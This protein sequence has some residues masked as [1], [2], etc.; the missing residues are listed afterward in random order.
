MKL[1]RT[2]SAI[3]AMVC[4]WLLTGL[5]CLWG[6]V[7][8][9]AA[10]VGVVTDSSGAVVP[11]AEV[12]AAHLETGLRRT[13]V[14]DG[15]GNFAILSLPIGPYAISVSAK[16]FKT[17]RLERTVLTVGE[18]QRLAPVLEVGQVTESIVVESTAELMQ[19]EKSSVGAVVQEK[20][21][22]DLPLNGRNPVQLVMLVPGMRF[23]LSRGGQELGSYVQGLGH[24]SDQTEFQLDGVTANSG[25]DEQ[26]MAIPNVDTIAEF[27]VETASFSAEYG[28]MPLQVLMATKAGTNELHG[29]LWEFLRNEKLD[30]F[31]A[32]AKTPGARKP[33]LSRNQFGAAVG[34]PIVRDRTHF[35]GS[36]EGTTIRQESIYNSTVVQPAML[37]GDFSALAKAIRDPLAGSPFPGNRI[38]ESRFSAASKYF[39]PYILLPNSPDGR[40]RAN[41]PNPNTNHEVTA[42]IDHQFT[43][44]HRLFGRWIIVKNAADPP[45]YK[46]D[47]IQER[48]VRQDSVALNYNWTIT[49][50]TLFTLSAGYMRHGLDF[51][52]AVAG[53]ENLAEKAGIQGIVT[54]GREAFVGLPTVAF[55][56][57]TGFSAPWGVPGRL[58]FNAENGKAGFNL[59]RGGHTLNFGYE[60][61]LRNTLG[62]HGSHSV[63]GNFTFNSQY[64]GDGFAD[65]LL[66]L[67]A[68][69]M[70]NYPIDTFGMSD[71]PYSGLY[72]QDFWRVHRNVTLNLGVRFDY[73]HE[74]AFV[75]GN[76]A[77]FDPRIGKGLA[78]E[79]KTGKV[80]LDAQPTARYLAEA[81]KGLWIPASQAGVPAGLFRATGFVSPRLGIAWR[82]LGRNDFVIRTGYGL[83]PSGLRGN[84]TASTIVGPP[85]WSIEQRIF[86]PATLQRWET[87]WPVDP[88]AWTTPS[89]S[90]A[91]DWKLDPTKAHEFNVSVQTALPMKSALTV[92]YVGV[93]VFDAIQRIA[94]NEVPPGRYVDLQAAKPYPVIGPIY[95]FQNTITK[96]GETWYNG[97]QVKWER[98]FV[99]GLSYTLSYAFSKQLGEDFGGSGYA[100]LI[101]PFAPKGYTRGRVDSD[102]THI[103]AINGVYELPF[104]R[105]RKYLAGLPSV[106]DAI[107]GGWQLTGIYS[108]TSGSPLSFD[109]PGATLGNGWGTRADLVGNLRVARPSADGWFNTAALAAPP[110]YTWGN[111][112]MGILD[113]PGTHSFD[114]GVMKNF[115]LRENKILQFRWEMFNMPNHVNLSNPVTTIGLTTTGKIFSAGTARQMQFGLKL[116]F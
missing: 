102:R 81:T 100:A 10:F 66:G 27:N 72:V 33:K 52:S 101:P 116:I 89:Y 77:T 18:R 5:P 75:N 3:S 112:G 78:G 59:I 113:G 46:P 110:P 21:I 35:F 84:A 115:P 23:L 107:L 74:K 56:G 92:S 50:T 7:G 88:T 109:V 61:N 97:L 85:F 108:F 12:T 105:G 4:F 94:V 68:S 16:G 103:L 36:Y 17:W 53:K 96:G 70:R 30:A 31:N 111:S 8:T 34:G 26:G 73:W 104:G 106:A 83:F 57:Y 1:D 15:A 60:L 58:W 32:F 98:R 114:A 80:N 76:G 43:D 95:I 41:A 86:S 64:T 9:E 69:T 99:D 51:T 40:F 39:F 44:R 28:R 20:Q 93:R 29:T 24:R 48:R 55:T 79:D 2:F 37:T 38:P 71:S 13:A 90:E 6:Q 62:R 42:R 19:T 25:M 47:V 22:R 54:R 65:Y 14:T 67:V 63:R 91:V 45:H 11:G 82:P 87:A 49:P